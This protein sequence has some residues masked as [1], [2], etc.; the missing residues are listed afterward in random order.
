MG[1]EQWAI[2]SRDPWCTFYPLC[3]KVAT[4]DRPL[5]CGKKSPQAT[6]RPT[7]MREVHSADPQ[8]TPALPLPS[9]RGGEGSDRGAGPVRSRSV[10]GWAQ[11]DSRPWNVRSTDGAPAPRRGKRQFLHL[12]LRRKRLLKPAPPKVLSPPLLP[13]SAQKSWRDAEFEPHAQPAL[14]RRRLGKVPPRV[15]SLARGM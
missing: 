5:P 13:R 10:R 3:G 9:P 8:R 2:T 14:V 4:G 7:P 11:A 15:T 1:N 6:D 12:G